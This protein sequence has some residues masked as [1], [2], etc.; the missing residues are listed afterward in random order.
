MKKVMLIISALFIALLHDVKAQDRFLE[1]LMV[2]NG[3]AS[4]EELDLEIIERYEAYASHPLKINLLSA[5]RWLHLSSTDLSMEM[6]F[7]FRNLL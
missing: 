1:S 2:L 3:I 7:R 5:N 6:C 4:E